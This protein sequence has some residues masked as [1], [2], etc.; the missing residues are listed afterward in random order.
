M[1]M[2]TTLA[3]GLVW[4]VRLE[5]QGW[6]FGSGGFGLG[7]AIFPGCGQIFYGSRKI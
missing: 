2:A 5:A 4:S 7:C 1:A 3:T 6:G